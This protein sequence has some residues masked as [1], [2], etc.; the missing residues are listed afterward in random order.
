MRKP[1][2]HTPYPASGD[3]SGVAGRA[4]PYKETVLMTQPTWAALAA[5]ALDRLQ[6]LADETDPGGPLDRLDWSDGGSILK[7]ATRPTGPD[8]SPGPWPI[9]RRP[10]RC[11]STSS[12]FSSWTRS[13]ATPRISASPQGRHSDPPSARPLTACSWRCGSARCSAARRLLRPCCGLASSRSSRMVMSSR[14]SCAASW[15]RRCCPK[16]PPPAS[17]GISDRRDP[18]RPAR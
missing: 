12:G 7:Q 4:S 17:T 15:R 2:P 6:R 13:A 11:P 16:V 5:T 14:S 9:S 8:R 1:K 10:C 18:T 3:L